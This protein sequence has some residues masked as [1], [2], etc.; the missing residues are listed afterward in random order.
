MNMDIYQAG[1]V[2]QN[3]AIACIVGNVGFHVFDE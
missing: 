3:V 1:R 2:E